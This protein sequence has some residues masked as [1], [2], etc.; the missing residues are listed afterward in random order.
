MFRL[1][2]KMLWHQTPSRKK[3]PIV[4]TNVTAN[5]YQD[6]INARFSKE[7][8]IFKVRSIESLKY[9]DT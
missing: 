7:W 2:T 8:E 9:V 6:Q 5:A 3:K 1:E 4:F